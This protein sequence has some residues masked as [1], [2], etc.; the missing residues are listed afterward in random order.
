MRRFLVMVAASLLTLGPS[1]ASAAEVSLGG[2]DTRP[3]ELITGPTISVEQSIGNP[4]ERITL[5]V[6]VRGPIVDFEAAGLGGPDTIPPSQ[7]VE[8][9]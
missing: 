2:P 3:G 8:M 1:L 6:A 5:R 7:I 4:D 9:R